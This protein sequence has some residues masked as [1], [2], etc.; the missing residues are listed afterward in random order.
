MTSPLLAQNTEFGRMYARQANGVPEV[1]SITTVIGQA[2]TDMDGWVGHMAATAVI[3]DQRLA[4]CVGNQAKLKAIARQA[5]SAAVEYRD[6]AA[7]RGDRVHFYAENIALRAMGK[8]H[9]CAQARET[10]KENGEGAFADRFDE[11]WEQFRVRPLAAEVTVWNSEVGY[12]GTLDL[13]AEIAGRICLIDYKTKGTDRNGR[14]KSLDPKVVIQL[15]AGL[16][17]QEI[18]VDPAAGTWDE[19]P[20]PKDAMLLGVALGETEVVPMMAEP[21]VL[22]AYWRRFWALRQVWE[23]NVATAGLG[24]PLRAVPAPPAA[25]P[26]AEPH[27]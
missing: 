5:S 24:H 26:A 17:A 7:R 13:V 16:K 3:Q 23:S 10:L 6:A 1:P 25:A 8:P 15:T 2:A 22:P 9:Q 12:A 19:W 21:H 4:E 27:A 20:Y 18:S 14:A 11:W